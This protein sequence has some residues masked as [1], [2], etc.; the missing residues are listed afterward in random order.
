[1]KFYISTLVL[2]SS[3]M[4]SAQYTA[5]DTML[6]K[7]NAGYRS[8]LYELDSLLVKSVIDYSSTNGCDTIAGF[9]NRKNAAKENEDGYLNGFSDEIRTYLFKIAVTES[10]CATTALDNYNVTQHY[11]KESHGFNDLIQSYRFPFLKELNTNSEAYCPVLIQL[12]TKTNYRFKHRDS[13]DLYLRKNVA[14]LV[15]D[16]VKSIPSHISFSLDSGRQS[17]LNSLLLS[18]EDIKQARSPLGTGKK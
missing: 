5:I 18:P 10:T 12:L 14:L 15:N 4:V 7:F 8:E 9:L 3:L 17:Y 1:M 16:V 6:W 11:Q 13:N 2:L